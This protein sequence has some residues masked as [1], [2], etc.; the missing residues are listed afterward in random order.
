V[1]RAFFKAYGDIGF[2]V[3]VFA[4]LLGGLS[5]SF[6]VIRRVRRATVPIA[7]PPVCAR[8]GGTGRFISQDGHEWPC[9]E[10]H[11]P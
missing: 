5:L 6:R 7:G 11:R 9:L 2:F 3:L 10:S 1:V 4:V 8:C